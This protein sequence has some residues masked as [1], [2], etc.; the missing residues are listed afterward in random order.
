MW[1][2]LYGLVNFGHCEIWEPHELCRNCPKPVTIQYLRAVSRA[3]WHI[4]RDETKKG[5]A[6]FTSVGL[7]L[8]IK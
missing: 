7:P 1:L 2:K 6:R 3:R 5:R 4:R 8:V